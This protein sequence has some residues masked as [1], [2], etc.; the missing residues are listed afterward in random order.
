MYHSIA[1]GP[2]P[3]AITPETFRM[4]LDML[5][6]CGFR[7]VA[8][9]DYMSMSGK[10]HSAQPIAVLTFDDGYE[11]F[12]QV[13]V[14]EIES[15]GWSATVFLPSD[16]IG[17]SN[18]WDPDGRGQRVMMNWHQ[19]SAAVRYGMELGAHSL[20][21]PDLTKLALDAATHQ[22]VASGVAIQQRTG[23]RVTS[24]AAPYGR[25]TPSIR[26]VI[27]RSYECAVGAT[28]AHANDES[29]RFDLPRIDMWYF[30]DPSRWRS[31]LEGS[32]GYFTLRR[33]LRAVRI[34]AGLGAGSR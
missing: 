27:A 21:H 16:L 14:P 33:A 28:M 6:R 24:F 31:Y 22:I 4:Q 5:D 1:Q 30:R 29:D 19:A 34:A 26:T 25:T 20:T 7:G 13:V 8:L 32:M 18:G 11:D 23:Q 15:R 9:R 17:A 3:L 2:A 10:S 12:A